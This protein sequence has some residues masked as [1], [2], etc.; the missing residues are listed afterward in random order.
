[1]FVQM[2]RLVWIWGPAWALMA[3]IFVVSSRSELPS[4]VNALD[5]SLWHGFTYGVLA[6][7]LLR[8]MVAARWERVTLRMA[9][10][11]VL[12]ATLYGVTDELHQVHVPLRT[13]E[14]SDLLA[15]ATGA[16]VVNGLVWGWSIVAKGSQHS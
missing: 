7:L 10:L 13:F 9:S 11:A 12:L 16:V 14:L 3:L 2:R 8:G 6:A 1:M 5:D 4:E 15:D